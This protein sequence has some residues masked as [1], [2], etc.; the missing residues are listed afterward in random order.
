MSQRKTYRGMV[1]R[2]PPKFVP[3]P[4]L[5]VFDPGGK[6]GYAVFVHGRLVKCGYGKHH[7]FLE[8]PIWPHCKGAVFLVER[9]KA[10]PGKRSKVDPNALM[11]TDFRA[12][13]LNQLYRMHGF[14]LEVV[15]PPNEWKGS[16]GKPEGD[17]QY[18]IEARVL[19]RLD[20]EELALLYQ[21]SSAR[22][23]KLDDNMIDAVGIGLWRLRRWRTKV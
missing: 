5:V 4:V 10:Y 3:P 12:G 6:L 16:I 17:E 2:P 8:Q 9:P 20:A 22:S 7:Q 15:S 14:E 18:E 21:S 11:Q 1:L 23:D 13:E 19:A